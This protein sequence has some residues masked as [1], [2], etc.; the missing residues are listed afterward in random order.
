MKKVRLMALL[1]VFVLSLSVVISCNKKEFSEEEKK[2]YKEYAQKIENEYMDY[3]N[4]KYKDYT[5]VPYG[6]D[7]TK[8][9]NLISICY[10]TWFNFSLGDKT[11]PPNISEILA[12]GKETGKYNWGKE[13]EFHYWA[14]PALGYYRSDNKEVIRTHMTQLA[15]A[16]VDF[17]IVDHTFMNRTR[18]AIQSE[19]NV[20][21]KEPCTVL[22]DTIL[23]MRAEGKKTPYVVFWSGSGE[24]TDWAV[25]QKMYKEFYKVD[26]WKDCFVYFEGKVLQL[27]TRIPEAKL[28]KA[29][30]TVRRMWGLEQNLMVNEWSYLQ[31][32]NEPNEN[33]AG[34]TEQMCVCTAAQRTYMS[35]PSAQGREHGI[36]MY[37]QWYHAFQHRPKVITITWWNEW[38]VQRLP[39]PNNPGEFVFTDNYNQEYSR[40]I[41]PMKG[42]HGDQYYQWMKEYIRAYRAMEPCPVLVESG[43]ED[44]AK[45]TAIMKYGDYKESDKTS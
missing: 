25:V 12:E 32:D 41:E 3:I 40:D 27:V 35:K 20:Y 39:D 22:L 31:H 33:L 36:F 42:G 43:Y 34:L 29:D 44:V 7:I 5:E 24:G 4:T 26:K 15:E 21:V 13:G 38:T 2:Q 14:E 9:N 28:A 10:T 30:V 18:T 16:G 23:E 6:L 19:W 37:T 1:L 45:D 11:N 17:I 8:K